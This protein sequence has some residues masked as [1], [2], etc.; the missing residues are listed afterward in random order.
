MAHVVRRAC[1]GRGQFGMGCGGRLALGAGPAER[2][3]ADAPPPPRRGVARAAARRADS[4]PRPPRAAPPLPPAAGLVS[5][6]KKRFSGHGFDLDL[7]Y[8]TPR[9]VAM[10]VPATGSE[11][12][13]RAGGRRG[14]APRGRRVAGP[15]SVWTSPPCGHTP[16]QRATQ[17]SAHRPPPAASP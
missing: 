15:A 6:Q 17:S 11:G 9:L 5:G 16:P 4:A 14:R 1:R 13:R 3:A 12:A 8:V 2:R 7:A 10:G